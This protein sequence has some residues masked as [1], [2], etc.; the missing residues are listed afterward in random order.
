M[1]AITDSTVS[2]TSLIRTPRDRQMCTHPKF[3][4]TSVICIE[5]ALKEIEIIHFNRK[6]VLTVFVLARFYCIYKI[7]ISG[8]KKLVNVIIPYPYRILL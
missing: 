5:K 4:L 2:R 1:T 3:V 6:F 7:I 8:Y